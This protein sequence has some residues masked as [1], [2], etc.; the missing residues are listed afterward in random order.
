MQDQLDGTAKS[1]RAMA[2]LRELSEEWSGALVSHKGV[3]EEWPEALVSHKGVSEEWS[4]ALVSHKGMSEEWSD[5]EQ[6]LG[7]PGQWGTDSR[8]RPM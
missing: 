6:D 4:G 8:T 3:S 5:S 1:A 2:D 7:K